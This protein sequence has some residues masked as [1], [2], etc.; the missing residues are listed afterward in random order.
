[1]VLSSLQ[2]P[3]WVLAARSRSTRA[4]VVSKASQAL[5]S[6]AAAAQALRGSGGEGG[7]GGGMEASTSGSGQQH[8]T[9]MQR[10]QG[11]MVSPVG[12]DYKYVRIPCASPVSPDDTRCLKMEAL[13]QHVLGYPRL[14]PRVYRHL[15]NSTAS[16]EAVTSCVEGLSAKYGR[17]LVLYLLR[18]CPLILDTDVA[19]AVQKADVARSMLDLQ[20]HEIFMILRKNPML[21]VLDSVEARARY[22]RLHRITPLTH[23]AVKLMVRKYP[24]V[25][26]SRSETIEAVTERMRHLAYTRSMWQQDFD[27]ISPSLLAFYLRDYA[28]LLLRLEYLALSGESATWTLQQVFKPSNNLFSKKHRGFREW[29]SVRS[30]RRQQLARRAA[31]AQQERP[32]Q[33]RPQQPEW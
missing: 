12:W 17:E 2:Q 11:G 30:A 25:L 29:L 5:K 7:Y 28:D 32:Q 1:M 3:Q 18:R 8:A 4:R 9:P 19:T 13:F 14:P 31:L 15:H 10:Y 24:L 22:D 6:A 20:P 21:L 26:N 27:C 16:V 33:E 23:E